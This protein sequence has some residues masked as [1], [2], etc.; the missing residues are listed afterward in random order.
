[1]PS[2]ALAEET[3]LVEDAANFVGVAKKGCELRHPVVQ[4][5]GL[6]GVSPDFALHSPRAKV[7]AADKVKRR[8][9]TG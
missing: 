5:A 7:S 1:V 3:T 9:A 2:L 6:L 8:Y 4:N